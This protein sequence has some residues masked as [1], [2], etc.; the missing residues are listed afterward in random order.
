MIKGILVVTSLTAM[1]N[2]IGTKQFLLALHY[3]MCEAVSRYF[4]Y[5]Q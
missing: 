2:R 5:A 4:R 3:V 1:L